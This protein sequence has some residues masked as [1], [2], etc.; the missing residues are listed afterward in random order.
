MSS[1]PFRISWF[2]EY[3]SL[4]RYC[5]F[6]GLVFQPLSK[7][8]LMTWD[9]WWH[10]ADRRLL[11]Y[12]QY[13]ISDRLFPE[14][15]EFIILNRVLPDEANTYL[16]DLHDKAVDTINGVKI[17]NLDDVTAAFAKPLD[18]YHVIRL[19]GTTFPLV[20]K[21]SEMEAANLR[22]RNKYSIPSLTRLR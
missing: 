1:Y 14:R 18:G 6:G 8:Y 20:L 19:D 9:K 7:E 22:I 3:E 4:P 2:N 13:H 10:T 11:Y 15:K 5:I 12:Y 16:S 17:T 21:A